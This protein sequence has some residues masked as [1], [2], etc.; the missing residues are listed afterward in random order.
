MV[1]TTKGSKQMGERE[2]ALHDLAGTATLDVLDVIRDNY[3]L[4]SY[5][6]NDVA[7][8]FLK[9]NK[10]DVSYKEIGPLQRGTDADRARLAKY[11][12]QDTVLAM[13]LIGKLQVRIHSEEYTMFT[14]KMNS[15]LF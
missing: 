4:R 3:K 14:L 12:L 5:K 10:D 6:L 2:V 1:K 11:C 13:D 7:A 9:S 8:H 15:R